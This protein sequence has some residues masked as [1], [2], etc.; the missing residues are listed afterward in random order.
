MWGFGVVDLIG[1]LSKPLSTLSPADQGVEEG[2][3][4]PRVPTRTRQVQVR[5]TSEQIEEL[6]AA[7]GVGATVAALALRFQV[8]RTTVMAQLRRAGVPERHADKAWDSA[9]LAQAAKSYEAGESLAAV[10]RRYGID[11]ETVARR[12]RKA[13]VP[14]RPRRGWH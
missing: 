6:V 3:T 13:G 1:Q 14:I 5:L 8:H 10:G 7:Y 4:S 12:L 11:A 2:Q 9:K